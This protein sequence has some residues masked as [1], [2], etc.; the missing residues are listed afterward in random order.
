MI[1]FT[2]YFNTRRIPKNKIDDFLINV[3]RM[4]ADAI[5]ISETKLKAN[6]SLNSNFTN[7][8]FIRNDSITHA[9]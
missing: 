9:G 4:P 6:S 1:I 2:V 8:K 7:H 3:E 5:A